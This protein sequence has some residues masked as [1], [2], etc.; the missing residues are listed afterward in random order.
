[1][2]VAPALTVGVIGHVDHGK[3]A[4]VR[5]LTGIE[6]DR[7]EE[8]RRR[9]ITIVLGFAHFA[10]G[11]QVIDLIDMPGHERFVRTMI[12]G[13]TGVRAVLLVVAA[14]EGIRPQTVEHAEIASLLG[15]RLAVI[16]ISK[17]DLVDS[18]AVAQVS[19]SASTLLSRLG[20]AAG[21]A[22]AV[23][24]VTQAGLPG[25]ATALA[26]LSAGVEPM[27]D[28]GAPYLPID[29]SF[30]IA[31]HGTVVTGTL[32]GGTIAAGDE[33]DLTPV[34]RRVRV[35]GVQVR[36]ASVKAAGPGQRVAVNLRAIEPAEARRGLAL[37]TPGLLMPSSWLT[38][39]LRTAPSA[40][41]SLA[42][43][44]KLRLL[45]GT[46]EADGVLRLLDREA[47]AP[48]EECLAQLRC[49]PRIS[50]PVGEHVVLRFASPTVAVAGGRV[51]D[52]LGSRLRR[53]DRAALSWASTLAREP[54][55]AIVAAALDRAGARGAQRIDL[56]RLSG[57]SVPLAEAAASRTGAIEAGATMIA[58]P[59]LA[60]VEAG[61]LRRLVTEPA[62]ISRAGLAQTLR[63]CSAGV[64]ELALV[65][66]GQS[67]RVQ[68]LGGRVRLL[69]AAEEKRRQQDAAMLTARLAKAFRQAGLRPSTDL[70]PDPAIREA[71]QRLVRNGVLIRTLDRVQK[72]EIL[73]HADAIAEARRKLPIILQG[74][75]TVGE[76]GAALGITRKYAVPLLEYLDATQ[77][78]RRIGDRRVLREPETIQSTSSKLNCS[79]SSS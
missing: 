42:S 13:A 45:F 51:L 21:P 59:A 34:G 24:A 27:A 10:V 69:R 23:S 60:R 19:A 39:A 18:A 41:A 68:F 78:T 55:A 38:L 67:R 44:A 40:S 35:R 56:A 9:G 63:G 64:L 28:F 11:E 4:L 7:L 15:V 66:L 74:G 46:S 17:C 30:S 14:N 76:V 12:A 79:A 1:M 52:A 37:A 8:E 54:P 6:T 3:T 32:R 16:A 29:R 22:H 71:M 75:A 36:G 2:S 5:A 47:V 20:F 65:R 62:G 48:G 70:P 53:H 26:A 50:L 58:A 25:L 43:G 33:L 49:T 77:F 57:L 72:R 61:I 31:G 73:F